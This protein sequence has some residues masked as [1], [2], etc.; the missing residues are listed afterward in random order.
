MVDHMRALIAAAVAVVALASTG[1]F[2]PHREGGRDRDERSHGER[3]APERR[4]DHAHGDHGDHGGE[5][6]GDH[7]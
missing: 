3:Q 2:W 6:D 1:C 7:R 5:R 4:G